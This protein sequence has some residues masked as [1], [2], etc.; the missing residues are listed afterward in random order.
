MNPLASRKKLLVAESELNRAQLTED[1]RTLT[2]E[3]HALAGQARTIG[4][5]TAAAAA[6][7]GGLAFFRRKK[8]APGS[9]KTSWLKTVMQGAGLAGT[10]W[11]VFR[12]RAKS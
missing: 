9:E 2:G 11:S 12:P 3:V 8:T 7:V 6:L 5:L 10:L 4:S 1:W